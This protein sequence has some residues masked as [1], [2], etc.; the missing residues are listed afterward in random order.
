VTDARPAWPG[1]A[2]ELPPVAELEARGMGVPL[3]L[4]TTMDEQPDPAGGV[5]VVARFEPG[6]HLLEPDGRLGTGILATLVDNVGGMA[7]GL[8]VLPDWIVTTNLA[9]RRTT[10]PPPAGSDGAV[11]ILARVLR[12]G[13]ST[14][15]CAVDL[16]GDDGRTLAGAVMTSSILTPELGPPPIPRP[17]RRRPVPAV[18]DPAYAGPPAGF[19]G[20]R[21]GDRPGEV[22][23]AA[24]AR[25]RNPW[26]IVHGGALAV[27]VDAAGRAAAA[28]PT[29]IDADA[30]ALG[31]SDLVMHF[32]SPGRVGPIV[33]VGEL[34]G[35]RGDDHLVRVSVRDRGADDRLLT[36][37]ALT[38]RPVRPGREES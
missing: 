16:T 11:T 5:Q 2:D 7:G 22:H 28:H 8:A 3:Y 24:P 35:S 1:A 4:P 34:V 38:V 25:V 12:R 29:G 23:L 15:V 19:F 37:A 33:A 26:G 32:L 30:D 20:L 13:R 6:T 27:A 14:V 17:L 21:P 10:A 9:V 18:D 31:V 36:L